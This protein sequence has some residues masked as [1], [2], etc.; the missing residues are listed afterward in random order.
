MEVQYGGEIASYHCGI[1]F[2][3]SGFSQ[4]PRLHSLASDFLAGSKDGGGWNGPRNA[5]QHTHMG[6]E[7]RRY[8]DVAATGHRVL[9]RPTKLANTLNLFTPELATVFGVYRAKYRT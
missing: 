3:R 1:S 7:G 5:Q 4:L 2:A 6:E 8:T 9:Q